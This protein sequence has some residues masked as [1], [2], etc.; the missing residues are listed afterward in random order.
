LQTLERWAGSDQ[1]VAKRHP[2]AFVHWY[3]AAAAAIH[4]HH[5]TV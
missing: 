5:H 4:R 1:L 2:P 3:R